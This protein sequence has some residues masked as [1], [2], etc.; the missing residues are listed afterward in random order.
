MRMQKCGMMFAVLVMGLALLGV[1]C[2]NGTPIATPVSPIPFGETL[3]DKDIAA[4]IVR[5]GALT[6]WVIRPVQPGLMDGRLE[7]RGKHHVVVE[8]AYTQQEYA[9]RYKDSAGMEYQANSDIKGRN[10]K[11]YEGSSIHPNYNK[12]VATLDRNIRLELARLSGQ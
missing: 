5:A 1:G 2:R 11:A 4:A 7:V 3:S 6:G 10:G 9:I 12:W 8:I